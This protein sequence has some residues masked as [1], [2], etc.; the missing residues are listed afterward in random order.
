MHFTFNPQGGFTSTPRRHLEE[1]RVRAGINSDTY[2]PRYEMKVAAQEFHKLHK[3]KINK[4]KGGYSATVNLIFQSWLKD[5]NIHVKDWNL[6]KRE[7]IQL[8]KDLT[9]ERARDEVEFYM[10]MTTDDQQTFDGLVNHHKNACQAGENVSKLIS[11]FM[12]TTRKGMNQRMSLLMTSRF[13]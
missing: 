8:V 13:W 7:T 3:P 6:T 11:D 1:D 10:G 4:L 12:V 2:P 5:V 9:A